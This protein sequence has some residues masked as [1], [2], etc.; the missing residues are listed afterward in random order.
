MTEARLSSPTPLPQAPGALAL[1]G[2]GW[3]W[4][5][6]AAPGRVQIA[7]GLCWFLFL[8]FLPFGRFAPGDGGGF[9]APLTVDSGYLHRVAPGLDFYS[10]TEAGARW[11]AGVDP[12]APPA[13]VGLQAAPYATD[14]R[15]PPTA[16]PL[17]ALPLSLPPPR[18]AYVLWVLG[19]AALVVFNFLYCVGRR[20]ALAVP[21]AMVWLAWFPLIAEFHMGQ[22]SL[23]TG[24]MVFHALE[25]MGRRGG[26]G[27]AWW[28]AAAWA[29]LW[30]LLMAP[31]LWRSGRRW[32]VIV[33][34]A[35]VA[36][37]TGLGMR[38]EWY[39]GG[40]AGRDLGASLIA[41]M[42]QPYAGR[43]GVQ[44]LVNAALWKMQGISFVPAGGWRTLPINFDPVFFV[45]LLV[46]AT[47]A[48]FCVWA[49]LMAPARRPIAP[50]GLAWLSWFILYNDCWEHHYTVLQ[51]LVGWL[52]VRGVLGRGQVVALW[53]AAGAP[54]LWYLWVK[55]GYAGNALAETVGL[56]YFVQRPVG[57]VV[58]AV[59]LA[60]LLER[61]ME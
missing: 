57:V 4:L 19:L 17:L 30:P 2:A 50:I 56:L 33:A 37:G 43:Q 14:F 52:M 9:L 29:K 3:R 53:L 58:L 46:V 27:G 39:G 16:L 21:F 31:T 38:W 23:L 7:V 61:E 34:V 45:A 48:A 22:F 24:S 15:Y 18:V 20:P 55:L 25:A 11:R 49:V 8:L 32:L 40:L 35:G 10:I 1:V 36:L 41:R 60:Q 5:A 26:A 6:G 44:A 12:Y 13:V 54:S 47:W 59:V 51:C 42:E 28:V